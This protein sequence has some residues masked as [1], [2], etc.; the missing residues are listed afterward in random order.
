MT[1]QDNN[2]HLNYL[3]AMGIQ[4]WALRAQPTASAVEDA[5]ENVAMDTST[6]VAEGDANDIVEIVD[7]RQLD[8]P[9][10]QSAVSSCTACVLHE[11]RT[12]T[13]FEIGRAHV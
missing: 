12:N 7:G 1:S 6:S 2:Q 5:V 13:V 4:A 10:L 9:A 8:W 11:S 3:Q